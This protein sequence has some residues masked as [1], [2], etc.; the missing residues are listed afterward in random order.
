M[1]IILMI[2]MLIMLAITMLIILMII[3]LEM[4]AMFNPHH[5]DVDH[6][7]VIDGNYIV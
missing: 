4:T 5:G 1:L 7:V 2:I 6:Q 3:I